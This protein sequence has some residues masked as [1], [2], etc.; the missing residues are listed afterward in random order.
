MSKSTRADYERRI[1]AL[2]QALRDYGRHGVVCGSGL[3]AV[4]QDHLMEQCT[5]GLA[6]AIK[7]R[8]CRA[9]TRQDG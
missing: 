4:W 2:K 6:D 7:E 8:P 3:R 5:C 9:T 1:T